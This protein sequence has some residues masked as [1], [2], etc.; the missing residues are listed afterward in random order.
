MHNL[1]MEAIISNSLIYANLGKKGS[2]GQIYHLQN[3]TSFVSASNSIPSGLNVQKVQEV[4]NKLQHDENF[5][6]STS[7]PN[8]NPAKFFPLPTIMSVM[9]P[10]LDQKNLKEKKMFLKF[11]S[12]N[13]IELG[14]SQ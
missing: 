12:D 3:A 13:Q 2:L 10:P 8:M 1:L 7:N 9:P 4:A 14:K 5:N 11:P 6:T